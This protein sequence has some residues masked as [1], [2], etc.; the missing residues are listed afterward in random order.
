MASAHHF[1]RSG[2]GFS[3]HFDRSAA[4][5]Q[6][7]AVSGYQEKV[8]G[9]LPPMTAWTP[10]GRGTPD[11]SA[12]GEGFQVIANGGTMSVGGTSASAPAFAAIVSLLNEARMAQGKPRLGFL[13]PF[14]YKH[15]DAFR[16][17][18]VGS[19]KIDRYSQPFQYG[20]DCTEG[21][22]AATGHGTPNFPKLLKAALA[23]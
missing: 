20:W 8:S 9:D 21:W 11:V 16:D 13:N 2:G 19:N 23:V 3:I 22:D 5:W 4:A 18:T 14:I 7:K 15:P 6:E 17:V 1:A 10:T 12:L